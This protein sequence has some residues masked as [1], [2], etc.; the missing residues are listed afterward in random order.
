MRYAFKPTESKKTYTVTLFVFFLVI[1][2]FVRVLFIN[3][4]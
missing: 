4:L 1:F 2:G 3:V